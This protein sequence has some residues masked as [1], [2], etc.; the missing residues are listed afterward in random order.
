MAGLGLNPTACIP[1]CHDLPCTVKKSEAIS[2]YINS[3]YY[4]K[5]VSPVKSYKLPHKKLEV[6]KALP[7]H[8]NFTFLHIMNHL[9]FLS[10]H[11]SKDILHS[12]NYMD[13]LGTL[14]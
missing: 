3:L 13:F 1:I 14:N 2:P 12:T 10:W 8:E 11:F 6:M 4:P 7:T 5:D 9:K